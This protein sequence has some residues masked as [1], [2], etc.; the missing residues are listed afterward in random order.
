MLWHSNSWKAWDGGSTIWQGPAAWRCTEEVSSVGFQKVNI[1][2]NRY[3]AIFGPAATQWYKLLTK[4][5]VGGKV[6]TIAARV[7]ADQSI[8]A[9]C[10]VAVFLSSMAYL[11]GADPKERLR[12]KYVEV[13]KTNWMVW[14]G[15][16]ALNFAFVPLHHRVLVV[17]F[18]SLGWN[19]Y[20]S[21]ANGQQ[22]TS[23]ATEK[24]T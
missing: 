8:F 18:V 6:P 15:V 9:T 21:W 20:L 10:N 12:S 22:P 17:N 13:L 1:L 3:E 16:Q 2:A 23:K 4:I 5:N 14:P 24:L 19:C 11:E 7:L